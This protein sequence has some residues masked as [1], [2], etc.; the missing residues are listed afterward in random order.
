MILKRALLAFVI[1][2]APIASAQAEDEEVEGWRTSPFHGQKDSGTNLPI[3]CTCRFRDRDF[4]VGD[5][6]CM[7]TPNNGVVI[8]RCDLLLNVTSWVPTKEACVTSTLPPRER[9]AAVG[10]LSKPPQTRPR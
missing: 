10:T 3:P 2:L 9:L 5:R 8:A 7:S 4:R 6:V 1:C